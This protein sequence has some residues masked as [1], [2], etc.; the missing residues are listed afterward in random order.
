[1]IRVIL[2]LQKYEKERLCP[3]QNVLN[4]F[5]FVNEACFHGF[6]FWGVA[7]LTP[8]PQWLIRVRGQTSNIVQAESN[9]A[10]SNCRGASNVHHAKQDKSQTLILNSQISNH[11]C[12]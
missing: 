1:M 4:S 9:R 7:R 10:C 11:N 3:S 2:R 5:E 6:L 8:D 12:K